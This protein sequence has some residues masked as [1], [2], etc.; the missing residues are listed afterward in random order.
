LT[1]RSSSMPESASGSPGAAGSPNE[2]APG[3]GEQ[4]GRTRK[5]LFGLIGSHISLARAE[6]SEIAGQ[7]KRVAAL[8]GAALFLLLLTSLLIF[9]GV[10]LFAG[11]AIFGSM[12]WGVLLGAEL[13][14]AIAGL[15]VLA[16]FELGWSRVGGAFVVALGVGLVVGGLLSY[17]WVAL[18]RNN[19]G[20]PS[21]PWFAIL[22]G[23]ILLGLVGALLGSSFGRS[24][25]SAG[26]VAGVVLG[27]LLGW[28]GSVGPGVRVAS[29]IGL[30]FL[31]LIWPITA[32]VLLFRHGIDT[33]KLRERFVP[34]QTIETTK[35][36]IEWVRAQMP[37]GPKS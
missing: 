15:L 27:A 20:L 17:D 10:L 25:A 16:I 23:A 14:I 1:D 36:T 30:A 9:V 5:A 7:I 35:E 29:A 19:P 12:G 11:E 6:F 32:A 2:P 13:L 3:L 4:F 37:L 33:A 8:A 18:N 22:S 34:S 21:E 24:I 28:L 26:A 31:L